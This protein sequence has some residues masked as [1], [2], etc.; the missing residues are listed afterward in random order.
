MRPCRVGVGAGGDVAGP[1]DQ[2]RDADRRLVGH[3]LLPPAVLA[4]HVAV[5][6]GEDHEGVVEHSA[7]RSNCIVAANWSSAVMMA[8]SWLWHIAWPCAVV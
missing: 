8:R 7:V 4:P 1:A 5:V 2:Q 3:E 6:G